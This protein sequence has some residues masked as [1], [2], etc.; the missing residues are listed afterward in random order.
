[1]NTEET[2]RKIADQLFV[3]GNGDRAKRL[4][5]ELESGRDGGGW[6]EQPVIDIIKRVLNDAAT[7]EPT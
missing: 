5:L 3:N 4:V 2:A 7:K 6:G 1:M